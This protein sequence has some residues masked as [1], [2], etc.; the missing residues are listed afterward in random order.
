M[1]ENTNMSKLS[2]FIKLQ[3]I[4]RTSANSWPK[5]CRYVANVDQFCRIVHECFVLF[6][7]EFGEN[8]VHVNVCDFGG[9]VQKLESFLFLF[10][11]SF[12][13]FFFVFSS[14]FLFSFSFFFFLLW[15]GGIEGE[16]EGG[17]NFI[18]WSLV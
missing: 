11:F 2:N 12:F 15:Q 14:F 10:S 5:I 8:I 3:R 6:S 13:F 18:N 4:W 7:P 17:M 16:R 9:A 1:R